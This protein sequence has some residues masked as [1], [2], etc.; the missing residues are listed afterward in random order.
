L[1][2]QTIAA[3]CL[4]SSNTILAAFLCSLYQC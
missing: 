3:I 4:Q 1:G 2:T